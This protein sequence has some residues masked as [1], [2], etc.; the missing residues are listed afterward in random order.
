MPRQ[1]FRVAAGESAFEVVTLPE[2]AVYVGVQV[3]GEQSVEEVVVVTSQFTLAEGPQ[4]Q[5]LDPPGESLGDA[6]VRAQLG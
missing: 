5:S 3:T 2:D 4:R 1:R 6:S